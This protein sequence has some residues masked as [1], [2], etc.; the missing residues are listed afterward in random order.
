MKII[1]IFSLLLVAAYAYAQNDL[2][3]DDNDEK[4]DSPLSLIQQEFGKKPRREPD[5]NS[6]SGSSSSPDS[7]SSGSLPATSSL[8]PVSSSSGFPS[9][10]NVPPPALPLNFSSLPPQSS[11]DYDGGFSSPSLSDPTPPAAVNL[12]STTSSPFA[13]AATTPSS[14]QTDNSGSGHLSPPGSS[15]DQKGPSSHD[16]PGHI[17]ELTRR[18]DQ[19]KSPAFVDDR[20]AELLY[21]H[22]YSGFRDRSG[23]LPIDLSFA[24][25]LYAIL[26]PVPR[27]DGNRSPGP[28]NFA[29]IS[30]TEAGGA[31]ARSEVSDAG[32]RRVGFYTIRQPNGHVRRVNYIADQNG[33]RAEVLT[34]EPGT[35]NQN[36]AGAIFRSSA[37]LPYPER[38]S[39]PAVP[40][41]SSPPAN[42]PVSTPIGTIA[43]GL[44]SPLSSISPL[45]P[46][47]VTPSGL[48]LSPSEV[49]RPISPLRYSTAAQLENRYRF[50][51]GSL[52]PD[53][54]MRYV[55]VP[56][57]FRAVL[58]PLHS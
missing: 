3:E 18:S 13:S 56:D 17:P 49:A 25:R 9:S 55:R 51:S 37:A 19:V 45:S 53:L 1:V 58:I 54:R 57:G 16:N 48:P 15:I 8:S 11:L 2:E 24:S 38:F 23:L 5:L 35:D 21:H 34:N 43:H 40:P 33:F 30:P 41:S 31:H 28:F 10:P 42:I 20:T 46:L 4:E 7:G 22:G 44:P 6:L 14:V 12:D 50:P 47:A 32:G 36:T 27:N 39:P 26:P 29:Y 52:F